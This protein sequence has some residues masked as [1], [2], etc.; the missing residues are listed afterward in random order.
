MYSCILLTARITA[1]RVLQESLTLT[2]SHVPALLSLS[3]QVIDCV[4]YANNMISYDLNYGCV[5][6]AEV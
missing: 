2:G 3:T 1:W 4:A 5:R 6:T